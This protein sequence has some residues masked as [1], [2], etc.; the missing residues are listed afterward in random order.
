MV[1]GT[2]KIVTDGLVLYFDPTNVRSYPGS[3][4]NL[5]DLKQNE[6][7][8]SLVNGVAFSSA[9]NGSLTFDGTNDYADFYAPNLTSTTTIQMWASVNYS[10]RCAH[11][12]LVGWGVYDV[13]AVCGSP[14]PLGYNTGNGDTYGISGA[15]VSS[16]GLENR[17]IHYTFEMREDVS[18][19]NNKIYTNAVSRALSQQG[20]TEAPASRTFNSG[21]GRISGWRIATGQ[22]VNMSMGIF[23][24]Y[25]RALTQAEITQNYEATRE[26]YGV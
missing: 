20:G 4:T 26:K 23:M 18:Y 24:I 17:W 2:P 21:N 11:K 10:N 22:E 7:T 25:N 6:Y 12:M 15:T 19:T 1:T 13:A 8:G 5:I 14:G 3:G 16:L 9:K